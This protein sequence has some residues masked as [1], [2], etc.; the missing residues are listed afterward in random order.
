MDVDGD[1]LRDLV[2]SGS[3][4]LQVFAGRR[5]QDFAEPYLLTMLSAEVPVDGGLGATVI[6]W[7]RDG[8]QDVFTRLT[9]GE[10][11]LHL[12]RRDGFGPGG[13][14]GAEDADVYWETGGVAPG[15]LGPVS[16]M[17]W[18]G[19]EDLDLLVPGAL[20]SIALYRNLGSS[21][22]GIPELAAREVAFEFGKPVPSPAFGIADWNGDG[23]PDVL[24]GRTETLV[25]PALGLTDDEEQELAR[26]RSQLEKIDAELAILNRT[27]VDRSSLRERLKQRSRLD[28]MA[29][30]HRTVVQR[31]QHKQEGSSRAVRRLELYLRRR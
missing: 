18:D 2:T 21:R 24:F 11:L 9:D 20:A 29:A 10:V 25:A 31:L 19:D 13:S 17:D 8:R 30:P 14:L 1:G 27:E 7:D 16:L 4:G 12:G 22:D 6:D 15:L 23:L 3:R 5:G 28:R 26:A